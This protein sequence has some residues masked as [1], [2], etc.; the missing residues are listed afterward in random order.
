ME[1]QLPLGIQIYLDERAGEEEEGQGDLPFLSHTESSGDLHLSTSVASLPRCHMV[2]LGSREHSGVLLE[3]ENYF[4][5]STRTNGVGIPS[6]VISAVHKYNPSLQ[7]PRQALLSWG[8]CH[9]SSQQD[10]HHLE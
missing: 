9:S 1:T 6:T 7:G 8:W 3:A 10:A 2:A 5:K 4:N